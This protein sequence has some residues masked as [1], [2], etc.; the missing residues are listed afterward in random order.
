MMLISICCGQ[1]KL[2]RPRA[3]ELISVTQQSS[4]F[5][6]IVLEFNNKVWNDLNVAGVGSWMKAY[7]AQDS[8]LKRELKEREQ[9]TNV[10]RELGL[11]EYSPITDKDMHPDSYLGADALREISNLSFPLGIPHLTSVGARESQVGNWKCQDDVRMPTL[12][13]TTTWVTRVGCDVPLAK[14]TNTEV[15]GITQNG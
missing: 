8:E 2:T 14:G 6:T 9:I 4:A 11:V 15:T 12:S 13:P 5:P 3:K 7:N 1:Q 10:F